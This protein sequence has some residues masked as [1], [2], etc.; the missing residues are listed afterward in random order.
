MTGKTKVSLV[1]IMYLAIV[2][3]CGEYV[4]PR[5]SNEAPVLQGQPDT[6]A[7]VGDTLELWAHAYDADGDTLAYGLIAY[8]TY[9]EFTEGYKPDVAM[10][11]N[12]GY[13][14]FRP[15]DRDR[16]SRDFAFTVDDGRGGAD[17][18]SFSVSVT[19]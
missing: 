8:V 6:T 17:S 7:A 15:R 10:S 11:K 13:F 9:E 1:A 19:E 2:C 3:G 12:T 14:L 5:L 16:P 4:G 18:T